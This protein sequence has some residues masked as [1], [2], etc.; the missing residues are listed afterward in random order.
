MPPRDSRTYHPPAAP[1]VPPAQRIISIAVGVLVIVACL[2]FFWNNSGPD[3]APPPRTNVVMQ[4]PIQQRLT[5]GRILGARMA[6]DLTPSSPLHTYKSGGMTTFSSVHE[7]ERMQAI[8]RG[9]L[10]QRG[11]EALVGAGLVRTRADIRRLLNGAGMGV[12]SV[13]FTDLTV[14]PPEGTWLLNS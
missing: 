6:L 5:D 1:V 13:K 2:V 10:G 11:R 8:V 12:A 7:M 14:I 3:P 9:Y 4:P